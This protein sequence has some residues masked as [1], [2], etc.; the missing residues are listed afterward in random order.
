MYHVYFTYYQEM[1]NGLENWILDLLK[2]FYKDPSNKITINLHIKTLND[3]IHVI[4]DEID[5][6]VQCAVIF[7]IPT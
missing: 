4:G 1:R 3:I 5:T 6:M 2:Y 7:N